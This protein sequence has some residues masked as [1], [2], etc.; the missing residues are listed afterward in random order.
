M[1]LAFWRIYV[2]TPHFLQICSET[3]SATNKVFQHDKVWLQR[4]HHHI[5]LPLSEK[6]VGNA[7]IAVADEGDLPGVLLVVLHVRGGVGGGGP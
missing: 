5:L 6:Q 3:L 7:H 4:L 1:V 2:E